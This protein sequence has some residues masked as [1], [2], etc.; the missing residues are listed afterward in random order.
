M[1]P[2]KFLLTCAPL[3]LTIS[4]A[5]ALTGLTVRAS[6][7]KRVFVIAMENHNWEQPDNKFTGGIQQIYQ[8][9][10]APFLNSL[11]EGNI[12]GLSEVTAFAMAYHNVLATA[13]G[14]NLH[15]DPSEAVA[16]TLWYAIANAV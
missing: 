5:I 14:N 13:S 4:G 2:R 9:P 11:V 6:D 1:M 12:P 15:I 16:R 7:V 3:A 10:A 8:N